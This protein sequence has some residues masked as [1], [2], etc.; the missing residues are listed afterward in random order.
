M[1]EGS[2]V[3]A[4]ASHH[5]VSVSSSLNMSAHVVLLTYSVKMMQERKTFKLPF[6]K[7]PRDSCAYVATS[8]SRRGNDRQ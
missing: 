6:Q 2:E 5:Q 7:Q 8:S 4:V 3:T 1:V